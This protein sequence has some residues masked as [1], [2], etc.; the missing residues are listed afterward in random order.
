MAVLALRFAGDPV[1]RQ[2]THVVRKIDASVQRLIDDMIDTMHDAHGVGLAAPQI[3]RSE[4][5][6]VIG[7]PE[8]E[9]IVLINPQFVKRSGERLLEEACLS[10]PGYVGE[11]T[12]H[13]AVTVKALNREGR[14]FRVKARED[15][16]A[17]ALEH[18]MDHLDG[19]LYI[20]YL[21]SPDQLRRIET[22][23]E[24]AVAEE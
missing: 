3:G 21:E 11:I 16:L 1:L 12:R 2:K 5:I 6:A 14:P 7:I 20:D 13:E 15:L 19:V 24:A 17:Q 18:E 23:E 10:V 4:R 22:L 8:E 9:V